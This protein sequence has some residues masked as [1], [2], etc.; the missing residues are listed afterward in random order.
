MTGKILKGFW[1]IIGSLLIFLC[2]SCN[3]FDS[4]G[5]DLLNN[6]WIH[7]KG[8][9]SFTFTAKSADLDSLITFYNRSYLSSN[10]LSSVSFPLGKMID[11]VFGKVEAAIGT[12]LRIIPT[13]NLAFL[14]NPIDS[15]MLSLRFDT[16][17]FYG[18]Y[19]EPMNF[20]VYPLTQAYNAATTYYSH[21]TLQYDASKKLGERI[22]YFPNR[23]D[24]LPLQTDTLKYRAFPQLRIALDVNAF[25]TILKS[26]SDTV[27]FTLD[28]FSKVF[29]GIA[30][31]CE[32]G[33]G[34]I[35]VQPEH[36][37][38]K[39]TIYYHDNGSV[40]Q[41]TQEFNMGNLAVKT[42][43]YK[44]DNQ[45]TIAG[46]CIDGTIP[47]DSLLCLQ[48]FNGRDIHITIPYDTKWNGKF[49]NFAVLQFY[50]QTELPGDSLSNYSL[51]GLLEI[52][53]VSG[54]TKVGI[55]DVIAAL[56]SNYTRVFGGNPVETTVNGK[57]MYL[58]K[59]NITRHFQKSLKAKTS[60]DLV[61][62]P[63]LKLESPARAVFFGPGKS[64]F[65][66]KLFLTYSE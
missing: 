65:S 66:A 62:S 59:M 26:Y 37:D 25:M 58:Y 18:K 48:G 39:V 27:Y 56:G 3:D 40:T 35:S 55:D 45:G 11:P 1:G 6:D 53:D 51:P 47:G 21:Y 31:V 43:E 41:S 2:N 57:S 64:P 50:A 54:G 34:I 20:S 32:Q 14:K 24:S 7:A 33:N 13:S 38:S 63:L 16:S 42:P 46:Q 30:I 36:S 60:M 22:A 49:I 8:D 12:Q 15:I 5:T 17:L 52:F 29:N 4:F 23:T 9:S 10:S 19:K 44:I 28:S 61:I